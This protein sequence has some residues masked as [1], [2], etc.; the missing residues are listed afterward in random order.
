MPVVLFPGAFRAVSR[1]VIEEVLPRRPIDGFNTLACLFVGDLLFLF[2]PGFTS[3]TSFSSIASML[4]SLS[5]ASDAEG[6]TALPSRFLLA[7]LRRCRSAFSAAS[8]ASNALRSATLKGVSSPFDSRDF[9][10]FQT[11]KISVLIF[12]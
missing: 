4:E 5:S 7:F 9:L 12:L 3:S 1:E 11:S 10:S 6:E 8:L 2:D